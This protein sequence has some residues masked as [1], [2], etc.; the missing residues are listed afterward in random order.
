MST[1]FSARV[2]FVLVLGLSVA[3]PAM[4]QVVDDRAVATAVEALRKAIVDADQP[5]LDRLTA[6]AL[7]YGHSDGRVEDKATFMQAL[8]SGKSDFVDLTLSDKTVRVSGDVAIARHNMTGNTNNSGVRGS[9]KLAVLTVWQ[10]Q[11]NQW[12]LLARQAVKL[13]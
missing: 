9:V 8:T 5:A 12:K 13:P 11:Q 4:A 10:K 1:C 6:A 2:G 3:A 7:S